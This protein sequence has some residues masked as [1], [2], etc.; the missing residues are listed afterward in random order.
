MPDPSGRLSEV[1]HQ[2]SSVLHVESTV[3]LICK[4]H[5]NVFLMPG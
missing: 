5:V 3:L 2:T 4:R 1:S